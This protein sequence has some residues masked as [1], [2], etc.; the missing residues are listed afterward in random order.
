[1]SVSCRLLREELP[2][3]TRSGM[4]DFHADPRKVKT[5]VELLPRANAAGTQKQLRQALESL[6]MQKLPSGQRL[7]ALEEMRPA[8]LEQC[9]LLEDS[10]ASSPLPLLPE[11]A[12]AAE[13]AESFHLLLAHGYRLAVNEFCGPSGSVPFLRGAAV[14]QALVRATGHYS[15][16]LALAWRIYHPARSKAWQGLHRLYR[17]ASEVKLET[18]PV[19]DSN[20]ASGPRTVRDLYLQ[21]L[22]VAITNP[23]GYSPSEQ[24]AMWTLVVSYLTACG[25]HARLPHDNAPAIPEDA[26]HGPG[27]ARDDENSAL[28]ID[29]RPFIGDVEQALARLKDGYAELV[30]ARGKGLRL[31]EDELLRLRRAFGLLAARRY[32]RLPGG[33]VV[34]TV[35]G[36]S[37][38][39]FYLAGQRDFD[40]FIRQSSQSQVQVVDRAAWASGGG[41]AQRLPRLPATAMDQSLGGYRLV[42]QSAESA[43]IRVGELVGITFADADETPEWMVAVVRWLRY[44]AD[45]SLSAGVELVSRRSAAVAL[46]ADAETG[47]GPLRALEL[48]PQEGARRFVAPGAL[49]GHAARI[50]VVMDADALTGM[51][52]SAARQFLDRYRFIMNTGEYVVLQASESGA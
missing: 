11:L 5:W 18:K 17:F 48:S 44:E 23:Y 47:S 21:T 14:T 27:A 3:F 51:D 6:L 50:E 25:L 33:H 32:T 4:G 20:A 26:D 49:D 8:V 9:R 1:M 22:L 2:Q 39:H 31:S 37:A 28:W 41:D 13:M 46:R 7:A 38:L 19:E 35:V 24:D 12:R 16:S 36:L 52:A 10:Y 30:P 15:R 40:T 29:L 42:W 45:G 43:R 34:D